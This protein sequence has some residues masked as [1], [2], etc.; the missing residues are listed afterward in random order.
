[1]QMPYFKT[2][3][4]N[5][6]L[7]VN[8]DIRNLENLMGPM[9]G[10]TMATLAIFYAVPTMKHHITSA[11]STLME[12]NPNL[13]VRPDDLLNMIQKIDT[14]SPSFDHS[15]EIARINAA[16]RFGQKDANR[17][18]TS[19]SRSVPPKPQS[20]TKRTRNYNVK[21]P[22][23]YCG[24]VGHWS[25]DCPAKARNQSRQSVVTVVRMG[26][27][28]TLEE[29][30]ALLDLG[31]THWV[32]GNISLF[33]SLKSTDMVL[34]VA[35]SNSF[36]VNG[37]GEIQLNTTNGTIKIRNVLYCKHISGTILLLGH[38]LD[39]DFEVHFQ[40]ENFTISKDNI[41]F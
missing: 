30:D 23:H 22:C 5:F 36:K 40:H 2:T 14:A 12:N 3:V 34:S 31:A 9:N 1:M 4:I 24:E 20:Y 10:N 26:I 8:E 13:A 37:I 33:T 19:H 16:S 21:N 18:Y 7:K 15:T 35:S 29:D 17:Q 27:V 6:S 41:L 32:V 11:I 28:P 39:E 38:L 25:P